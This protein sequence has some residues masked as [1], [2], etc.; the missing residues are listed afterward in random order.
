[1]KNI[2]SF[3]YKNTY[4]YKKYLKEYGYTIDDV[5]GFSLVDKQQYGGN[6]LK[7]YVIYFSDHDNVYFKVVY[8][9]S[10][11]EYHQSALGF[12]GNT[13]LNWYQDANVVW[14]KVKDIYGLDDKYVITTK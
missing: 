3:K 13:L 11:N 4:E 12:N 1:M 7:Q 8:F 5:V 9:K 2:K 10:L 6:I 14:Y